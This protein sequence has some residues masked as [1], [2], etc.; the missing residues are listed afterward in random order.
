MNDKGQVDTASLQTFTTN[1]INGATKVKALGKVAKSQNIGKILDALGGLP[2]ALTPIPYA[3]AG[4]TLLKSTLLLF[5]VIDKPKDEAEEQRKEILHK[6]DEQNKK[7]DQLSND[8]QMV[9]C[10]QEILRLKR[11]V[12]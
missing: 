4:F 3:G 8:L 10:G 2:W 11:H 1:A 7:L 5:G 9:N 12:Y 6:L